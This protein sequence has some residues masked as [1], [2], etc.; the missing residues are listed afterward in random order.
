MPGGVLSELP[1]TRPECS[2]NERVGDGAL[3]EAHCPVALRASEIPFAHAGSQPSSPQSHTPLWPAAGREDRD[4]RCSIT[5]RT[6][7]KHP[8]P[9]CCPPPALR[10]VP[11]PDT[12]ARSTV[13]STGGP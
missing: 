13:P 10:R 1:L 12:T 8:W 3:T 9:A 5:R 11:C 6:S 2:I 7:R 4:R